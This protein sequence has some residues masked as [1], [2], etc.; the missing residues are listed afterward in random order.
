MIDSIENRQAGGVEANPE[1]G[2]VSLGGARLKVRRELGLPTSNDLRWWAHHR[3]HNALRCAHRSRTPAARCRTW[4]SA[5]GRP[6]KRSRRA[7]ACTWSL[8]AVGGRGPAHAHGG[9]FE[10]ASGR[11]RRSQSDGSSAPLA[12]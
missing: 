8:P 11:S 4:S 5:R 7:G 12:R 9:P 1:E 10:Q 6:D 2:Y 3:R